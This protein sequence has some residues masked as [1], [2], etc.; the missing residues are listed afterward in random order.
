MPTKNTFITDRFLLKTDAARELYFTYAAPCPIYDYHCH[1]PPK[2]IADD[3][4]FANLSEIWLAGDHYKWR[5]M[6]ANGVQER[7]CTGDASAYEKFIAFVRCVPYTLRNPIYHWSHLELLRYF[8]IDLLINEENAPAIWE[9]A[10]AKLSTPALSVH[11]ILAANRVAVIGT[12][13]DPADTLQYHEQISRAGLN[14]KV[15]PTFRPD[16]ALMV[17]APD[18]L[19]PWLD[20]LSNVSGIAC[21]T[22]NGLLDA[23]KKRHDD[24]HTLGG[25]VS[26]HGLESCFMA[27]CSDREAKSIFDQARSGAPA[28][29]EQTQKF[30][31]YLMLYFGHL[32]AA[33]GWTQQLHLGAIR[34]NNSRLYNALGADT[35]FDS[36]SDS[37]Q[38]KSLAFYLNELDRTNQLPKVVIYNLNPADNYAVATM[39][40]NFQDGSVAGKIQFGSGW[41]FLDQKEGIEWQLNTL[42]QL[43]LLRRFVGMVTDSRS[44]LSYTRH[45]Y[46]RRV[47]CNLIGSDMED[48]LLPQDIALLGAMVKEICFD[49]AKVFFNQA[50]PDQS[51]VA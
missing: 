29:P 31:A 42:S 8:D 33:R 41:W 48:G 3:H 7:F 5:L 17:N 11:G 25:R 1:L 9:Q 43:G 15:Y 14:T 40:G 18:I 27:E 51:A 35:G 44:F 21:A 24:F 30:G 4:R 47:L 46:F 10:N 45:E 19:N 12:T 16:K 49:N 37:P 26:D 28:S 2:Q 50:M 36:I 38:I 32:N 13:D 6:R 20:R 22:L 23:L 39:I 34:N